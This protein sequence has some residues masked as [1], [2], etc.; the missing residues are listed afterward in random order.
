MEVADNN[1]ATIGYYYYYY[2][3]IDKTYNQSRKILFHLLEEAVYITCLL[4]K[5]VEKRDKGNP[6]HLI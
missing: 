2:Y 6:W 5:K 3:S 1:A 4:C